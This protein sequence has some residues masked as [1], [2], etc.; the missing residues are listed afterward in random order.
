MNNYIILTNFSSQ[1]TDFSILVYYFSSR[2]WDQTLMV[3]VLKVIPFAVTFWN[4]D[5]NFKGSF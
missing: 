1:W 3:Y 2:I 5:D 4:N